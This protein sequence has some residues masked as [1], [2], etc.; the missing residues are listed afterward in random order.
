MKWSVGDDVASES[1]DRLLMIAGGER[2]RKIIN[3]KLLVIEVFM[4]AIRI[5][6]SSG[7]PSHAL[8]TERCLREIALDIALQSTRHPTPCPIHRLTHCLRLRPTHRK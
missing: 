6:K 3:F 2:K 1:C 7:R 5:G 4:Q 8:V